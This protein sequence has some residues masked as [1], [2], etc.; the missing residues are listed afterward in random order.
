MSAPQ[1]SARRACGRFISKSGLIDARYV[2]GNVEN[3][4]L[5]PNFPRKTAYK[6]LDVIHGGQ[7][8]GVLL[9]LRKQRGQL[10]NQCKQ[11]RTII[12]ITRELCLRQRAFGRLTGRRRRPED[13]IRVL[14][15]LMHVDHVRD[16]AQPMQHPQSSPPLETTFERN[17]EQEKK[18]ENGMQLGVRCQNIDA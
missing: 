6:R 15:Q 3:R 13:G 5:L 16:A 12:E 17:E 4:D 7:H 10:A 2:R 1:F 14:R 8:D 18:R 9:V 11:L